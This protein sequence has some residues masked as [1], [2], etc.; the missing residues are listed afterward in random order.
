M[1]KRRLKNTIFL[2][3]ALL[4]CGAGGLAAAA[5]LPSGQQALGTAVFAGTFLTS[6][7]TALAAMGRAWEDEHPETITDPD[8]EQGGGGF[9]TGLPTLGAAATP[10]PE[11]QP[12]QTGTRP[13]GALPIVESTYTAQEGKIY[14][15]C[16]AGLVKNVTDLPRDEVLAEML[17]P[18]GF[19]LEAGSSEPQV[20]IMHTHATE[21]YQTTD[22]LWYDPNYSA[23]STDNSQNMVAV[24]AEIAA[25]LNQNGIVTLQDATQHDYP[26]YNGSYERSAE[27]IKSYLEKYPT[28]NIALDVHR[29]AI[30]REDDLI[31]KPTV[32]INGRK[33][34]QLMIITGSDDG[35]MNVPEWREN[36]RFAAS[37]QDAI[38]QD[39]PE[40]TRPI[41]FCY[42][43]Y[44]MDLT[45][46][47]LLLEVGS[48]ANTLDESVY[49]AE[50][51]GKSL[52]RM[53]NENREASPETAPNG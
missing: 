30:Q 44:N 34:A 4:L 5:L 8:K 46:G 23:R 2:L 22:D 41:F 40:L 14:I 3:L 53:L 31:V 1:R 49:T 42:R 27:T 29:D 39:T 17:Q 21:S 13:E 18:M 51:V 48:N 12:A 45:T 7:R 16:G 50:L 47:S 28:I 11:S 38:E 15:P 19:Q 24:G 35:T 52:A 37:L 10:G 33:A 20:L 36:L 25:V 32:E 43:K 26:S 9:W 6:P